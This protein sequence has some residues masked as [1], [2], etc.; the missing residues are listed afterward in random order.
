MVMYIPCKYGYVKPTN[1][2]TLTCLCVFVLKI[3]SWKV[4]FIILPLWMFLPMLPTV[5]VF[6]RKIILFLVTSDQRYL[7]SEVF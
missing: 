6:Q 2:I 3:S 1:F 5:E 4:L 7:K